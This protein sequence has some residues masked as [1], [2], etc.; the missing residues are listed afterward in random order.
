MKPYRLLAPLLALVLVAC[1][2]GGAGDRPAYPDVPD[3]IPVVV[4]GFVNWWDVQTTP[5]GTIGVVNGTGQQ[6][7]E[8]VFTDADGDEVFPTNIPPGSVWSSG[9][10]PLP[11]FYLVTT[12]GADGRVYQRYFLFAPDTGSEAAVVSNANWSLEI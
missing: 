2:G 9:V 7:V 6:L 3:G 4:G 12:T 8:V 11:G 10:A 1:G 5:D